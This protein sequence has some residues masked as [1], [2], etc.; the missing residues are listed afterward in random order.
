MVRVNTVV[1][2][3]NDFC[4][5]PVQVQQ[6]ANDEVARLHIMSVCRESVRQLE[7]E[8]VN[9]QELL[10]MKPVIYLN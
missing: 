5:Q 3:R 8:Y 6:G 2:S 7:Y 1:C 10:A 9:G 4:W